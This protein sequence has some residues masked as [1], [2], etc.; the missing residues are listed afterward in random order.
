M[1]FFLSIWN[2]IDIV[3]LVL[4]ICSIVV[5]DVARDQSITFS[6]NAISSF[7]LWLKLMYFFRISRKTGHLVKMIVEVVYDIRFF[8]SLLFF[9][10]LAFSG[11]FYILSKSNPEADQFVPS[12]LSSNLMIYLLMLGE[13]DVENFGTT[14]VFLVWVLFIFASMFL[15]VVMLNL[16]IAIISDTF[17]RVQGSQKQRMY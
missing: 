6:L 7:F 3:P 4:V 5:S 12:M 11:S 10:M 13:F 15:I 2:Y 8:L 16:L 9:A 1:Q 17:E 14:N